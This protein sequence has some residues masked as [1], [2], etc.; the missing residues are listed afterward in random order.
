MSLCAVQS[1][2]RRLILPLP[3]S[4][5][6]IEANEPALPEDMISFIRLLQLTGEEW[7]EALRKEQI[8]KPKLNKQC[9]EV[10][11]KALERRLAEYP[12]S[13]EVGPFAALSL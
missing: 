5:F 8:P 12:T 2:I 3:V 13:I 6:V 11:A 1:A 10:A 9:F 4:V 7:Q